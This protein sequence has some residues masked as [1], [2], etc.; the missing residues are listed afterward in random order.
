MSLHTASDNWDF[1]SCSIEEK[2]HSTMVNLSLHDLAPIRGLDWFHCLEVLLK[3]P[4]PQNGMTTNEEFEPLSEIEDFI[5]G[6]E[7]ESLRYVARQTGDGRRKFYFY[8]TA[9]FKFSDFVDEINQA[10]PAYEKSTFN[11]EDANWETYFADLYPN[12]MAMNEIANRSVFLLLEEHGDN[13]EVLREI[14]HNF[15]FKNR[16]H[17]EQLTKTLEEKGFKVSTSTRGLFKKS[18]DLLAQRVD[19]PRQL[20][21]ITFELKQL[22][23]ELG[24]EYD[25]WGCSVQSDSA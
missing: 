22:A 12:A 16:E 18:Y 19:A 24:G 8:T 21:P 20:D 25:G 6:N 7:T 2:P 9:D 4:N 10:F 3:S 15:I 17:A 14:D 13:L 23:D 1:Y 11:F 5:A